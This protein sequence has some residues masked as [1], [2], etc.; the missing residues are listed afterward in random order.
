MSEKVIDRISFRALRFAG[1]ELRTDY[2]CPSAQ[3]LTL[4][5]HIL[6]F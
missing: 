5:Q 6:A 2:I 1:E 4:N 3:C